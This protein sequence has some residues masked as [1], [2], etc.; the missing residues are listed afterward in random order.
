MNFAFRDSNVNST[1]KK[2]FHLDINANYIQTFPYF[3]RNKS[4]VLEIYICTVF[5]FSTRTGIG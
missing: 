2:L 5:T 1:P 4:Q 3:S